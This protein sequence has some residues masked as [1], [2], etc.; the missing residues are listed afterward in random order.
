MG[1]GVGVSQGDTEVL[2]MTEERVGGG[3]KE[4]ETRWR[5]QYGRLRD[6]ERRREWKAGRKIHQQLWRMKMRRQCGR[7]LWPSTWR[8]N[9]DQRSDRDRDNETATVRLGMPNKH[10][11][12]PENRTGYPVIF[13]QITSNIQFCFQILGHTSYQSLMPWYELI[14]KMIWIQGHCLK[15][16]THIKSI[17]S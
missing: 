15:T 12:Q 17:I 3:V 2:V 1:T 10:A 14:Q 16:Y 7:A 13:I 8:S 11:A 5:T 4:K 6:R 9:R